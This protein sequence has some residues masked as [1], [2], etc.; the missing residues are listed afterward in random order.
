VNQPRNDPWQ[1]GP[2]PE[3]PALSA[4]ES[5]LQAWDD[6]WDFTRW[7]STAGSQHIPVLSDAAF[8]QLCGYPPGGLHR[9]AGAQAEAEHE[10]E[11]EAE[12]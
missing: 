8:A 3:P 9:S 5:E 6:Y 7:E 12:P 4:V 1:T 10:P 11:A 2:L